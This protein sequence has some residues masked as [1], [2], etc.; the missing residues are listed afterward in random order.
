M[1]QDEEDL[2]LLSALM[3]AVSQMGLSLVVTT[4]HTRSQKV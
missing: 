1:S 2:G 3:A 4:R